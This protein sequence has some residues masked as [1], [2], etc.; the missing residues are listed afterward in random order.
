[1]THIS[2]LLP[3]RTFSEANVKEHWAVKARRTKEH[4]TTAYLMLARYRRIMG[5]TTLLTITLTRIASRELDEHDNLR[6]ALKACAD[7]VADAF[8]VKDKDKRLQWKYGQEKGRPHE[9]AVRVEIEEGG[10]DA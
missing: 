5:E 3:I 8:G 7:G 2:V 9:Y 10:R 6:R 4:R 1:M